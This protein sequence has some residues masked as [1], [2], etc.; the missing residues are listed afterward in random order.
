MQTFDQ[1]CSFLLTKTKK[2]TSLFHRVRP[3]FNLIILKLYT[4]PDRQNI[5][6]KSQKTLKLDKLSSTYELTCE[7]LSLKSRAKTERISQL[8]IGHLQKQSVPFHIIATL[9]SKHVGEWQ[10]YFR[11]VLFNRLVD[12][13]DRANLLHYLLQ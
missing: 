3:I 5:S 12:F 7:A 4:V 10:F 13:L 1:I 8:Y 11:L 9:L 6:E 2:K